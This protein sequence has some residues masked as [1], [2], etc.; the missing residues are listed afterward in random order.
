M[1]TCFCAP[2]H[3]HMMLYSCHTDAHMLFTSSNI[4]STSYVTPH[5]HM[6]LGV[7]P[8]WIGDL[9]SIILKT[10]ELFPCPAHA[11]A[12]F[13][14]NRKSLSQQLES[15]HSIPQVREREP[16]LDCF[17]HIKGNV[18]P[19]IKSQSLFTQVVPNLFEF[20]LLL[21]TKEEILKNV[22]N[23]TVD[24]S[25]WLPLYFCPYISQWLPSNVFNNVFFVGRNWLSFR[26][27]HGLSQAYLVFIDILKYL[28]FYI[29]IFPFFKF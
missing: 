22:G 17:G 28:L 9:D 26:N 3:K 29:F 12:G 4:E 7:H 24:G 14:G 11:T 2:E 6:V 18:H 16:N 20:F 21:S 15:P 13:Y 25:H 23:Q 8:Y 19:K 27:I 10:P 5:I 1:W